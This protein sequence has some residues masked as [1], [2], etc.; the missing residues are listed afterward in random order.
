MKDKILWWVLIYTIFFTNMAFKSIPCC[1]TRALCELNLCWQHMIDS[2]LQ[3]GQISV[4]CLN[5]SCDYL[6][7]DLATDNPEMLMWVNAR[8]YALHICEHPLLCA[9]LEEKIYLYTRILFFIH[10]EYR[11]QSYA[12][13]NRSRGLKCQLVK[14]WKINIEW[15]YIQEGWTWKG[16]VLDRWSFLP[17]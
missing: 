15:L 14:K 12:A 17:Q 8:T 3:M 6:H 7:T 16:F 1:K 2:V 5:L 10:G 9:S 4:L 13:R 11:M